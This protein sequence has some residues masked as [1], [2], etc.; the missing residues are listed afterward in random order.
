M[1]D[2]QGPQAGR[3]AIF[4]TSSAISIITFVTLTTLIIFFAASGIL[5]TAP[6]QSQA[7]A[8][9]VLDVLF[10]ICL[11]TFTFAQIWGARRG[12]SWTASHKLIVAAIV[13]LPGFIALVV[14][15]AVLGWM[16]NNLDQGLESNL[17]QNV[18]AL[19]NAAIAMWAIS[20][21]AQIV[22]FTLFFGRAVPP[23]TMLSSSQTGVFSVE[24]IY[25]DT[26]SLTMAARLSP[27]FFRSGPNSPTHSAF[28]GSPSPA[29]S[30][31]ASVTHFIRPSASK[32]RLASPRNDSLYTPK[33]SASI[34]SEQKSDPVHQ[35]DGF[36][37]WAVDCLDEADLDSPTQDQRRLETIPGSRPPSPAHPLDGPFPEELAPEE[38]PLPDSPLGDQPDSL[39]PIP[40][41]YTPAIPNPSSLLLPPFA[42][43]SSLSAHR[44]TGRPSDLTIT[45]HNQ[46]HIHPLFRTNSPTPPPTVSAG[47]IVTGSHWGGQVVTPT[48]MEFPIPAR[49]RK[50][51]TLSAWEN[52]GSRSNGSR[53][54][55]PNL[56]IRPGSARSSSRP[57]SVKGV[58]TLGPLLRSASHGDLK[59]GYDYGLVER[60][61]TPPMP[62]PVFLSQHQQKGQDNKDNKK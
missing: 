28:S 40:A 16:L 31:L 24:Q 53:P 50:N 29:G 55:S 7:L 23:E 49:G 26:T 42:P 39:L 12:L 6:I 62:E 11:L 1:A 47:T 30:P 58:R 46:S 44:T 3:H 35:E 21:L 34:I 33:D 2:S 19:V 9:A 5:G 59:S 48:D 41:I 52:S 14:S 27:S 8:A 20:L 13:I 18:V 56:S 60:T 25:K 54:C 4:F 37:V 17:H 51:S 22:S 32:S 61:P 10:L 45:S 38:I 36:E 57:G 15:I 43:I